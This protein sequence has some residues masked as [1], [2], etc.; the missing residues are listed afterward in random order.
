MTY[1]KR[2]TPNA[3]ILFT[4]G[5][6]P[7]EKEKNRFFRST[8]NHLGNVLQVLTDRKLQV[9]TTIGSGVLDYYS[10][11]VVSQSDYFP[12]GMV[13]S[14]TDFYVDLVTGLD[15]AIV[16]DNDYRYSFQRQEKDDE[17]KGEDNSVNYKYRM[18]DPRVGRFFAVDPLAASFP[19]NAPYNFSENRVVD[20]F[21]LEG[22]EVVNGTSS[23]MTI[24][25]VVMH[26]KQTGYLDPETGKKYFENDISGLH[27]MLKRSNSY[28]AQKNNKEMVVVMHSCRTGLP[29]RN[30]SGKIT[31]ESVGQA[32]SRDMGNG[33]GGGIVIAP[34]TYISFGTTGGMPKEREGTDKNGDCIPGSG[35][36]GEHSGEVGNWLIYKD[37]V[38]ISVASGL[39][40][41]STNMAQLN[42]YIKP[43][44]Y[45]VTSSEKGVNKTVNGM[46]Y[47]SEPNSDDS[48]VD[49]YLEN[50]TT[51]TLTGKVE[52]GYMEF[53]TE[54]GKTGWVSS[55]S[56]YTSYSYQPYGNVKD[57]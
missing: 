22:L 12:F 32:L 50:G 49:G 37:G 16:S 53:E 40:K 7:C 25:S 39:W 11:D 24:T 19:F 21:E 36:S 4:W 56:K 46:N 26:G 1:Q 23:G 18:H 38:L 9:E 48:S 51:F 33:V 3:E 45:T 54:D 47:R 27:T 30:A 44:T 2:D 35:C 10:A 57:N 42:D 15:V 55:D 28:E 52:N 8:V 43:L 6:I 20:G 31:K 14:N 17:I 34:D 29:V 13:Y 41:P 5:E